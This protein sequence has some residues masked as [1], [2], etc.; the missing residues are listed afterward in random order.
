MT[1]P[2]FRNRAFHDTHGRYWHSKAEYARWGQL[3]LL[4]AGGVISNLKRQVKFK[5]VV[6]GDLICNYVADFVYYE[7][8]KSVI[9]DL[10]SP[11]TAAESAFKIKWAL[12]KACHPGYEYRITMK[13]KK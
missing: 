3:E 1:K 4:Q 7:A 9:E 8:N 6:N 2:K 10:K 11:P 13:G 5:C 12:M